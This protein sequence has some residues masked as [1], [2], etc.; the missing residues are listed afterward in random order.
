MFPL[1]PTHLGR[2]PSSIRLLPCQVALTTPPPHDS[3][4]HY[5]SQLFPISIPH[6]TPL[7]HPRMNSV[8]N[9]QDISSSLSLHRLFLPSKNNSS[10]STVA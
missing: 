7:P 4:S 5:H 6:P 9:H 8:Y 10:H 3:P 2:G 1:P